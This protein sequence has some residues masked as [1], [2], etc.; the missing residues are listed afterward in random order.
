MKRFTKFL[1]VLFILVGLSVFWYWSDKKDYFNSD[2]RDLTSS[3]KRIFEWQ[4]GDDA[5]KLMQRYRLH[6]FDSQYVF[7]RQK[8]IKVKLF[9]NT[10]MLSALTS[11]TL[12][13]KYV[14][15]FVNFCNDTTNFNWSETTWQLNESKYY[16][17]LYNS[18]GKAVGK[19]YFCLDGCN[20]T[21]AIPFSPSM[22]FGGLSPTAL[23]YIEQLIND[24]TKWE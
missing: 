22:K 10:P 24:K 3:Q 2:Y 13:P 4:E 14:D 16:C 15:S 20:M 5:E 11:K 17:R 1:V 9:S 21:S 19:I 7:P 6:F 23:N 8:V 18:T 12:N